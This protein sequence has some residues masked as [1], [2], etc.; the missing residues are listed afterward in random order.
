MQTI[1]DLF[2]LLDKIQG[3]GIP[4]IVVAVCIIFGYILKCIKKFP[5]DAIPLVVII[6]GAIGMLILSP[7]TPQGSVVRAWHFRNFSIGLIFGFVAWM[8][9]NIMLSRIEDY[10]STKFQ[11][12]G[13]LLGKNPDP[14]V[15]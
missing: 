8:I 4:P 12:V 11:F 13:N 5:N 15:S 3:W 2:G 10:L 6:A 14:P 7:P 9:H 1:N